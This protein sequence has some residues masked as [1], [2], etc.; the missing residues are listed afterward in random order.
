[1]L[2]TLRKLCNHPCLLPGA[3]DGEDDAVT[4]DVSLSGAAVALA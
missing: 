1:M 3:R 4:L 2:S